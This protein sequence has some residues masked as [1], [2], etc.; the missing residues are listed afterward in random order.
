MDGFCEVVKDATSKKYCTKLMKERDCDIDKIIVV[1][2]FYLHPYLMHFAME[3]IM[4]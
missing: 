3:L 4:S 2:D 1:K